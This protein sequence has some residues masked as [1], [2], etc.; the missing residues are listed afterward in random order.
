MIRRIARTLLAAACLVQA[1]VTPVTAQQM[2][3]VLDLF[4]ALPEPPA[5]AE[6]A[7]S[8]FDANGAVVQPALADAKAKVAL[9]EK[10]LEAR[11]LDAHVQAAAQ[12]QRTV[13]GLSQGM[14]TAGFDVGRMQRDPAYAAQVQATMKS[15][16]PQ[17]LME[18]SMRMSSNATS[19]AANDARAASSDN[20]AARAAAEAAIRYTT[21]QS[22]RIAARASVW[23]TSDAT[24]ARLTSSPPPVSMKKPA[25]QDGEGC[26]APCLAALRAYSAAV[27]RELVARDTRILQARR[28]DFD[29]ARAA[30][31]PIVREA[32]LHL[33][34][35]RY[36]DGS[37]SHHNRNLILGLGEFAL[38]EVA[39]LMIRLEEIAK[40]GAR[41]IR[42]QD[43]LLI[44]D[45]D[46]P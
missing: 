46:R 27:R 4:N 3:A 39:A 12:S 7:A 38:G 37:T 14:A 24:V 25:Q 30:A 6:A 8:W 16:S 41:T 34:A 9:L 15:M 10:G 44:D 19:A 18:L 22:D 1:A 2:P 5:T 20:D 32:G 29:K 13:T 23:T 43:A 42:T 40:E 26:D 11:R 35:T 45:G 17:Q 36:G 28:G 33:Q 21:N 31:A